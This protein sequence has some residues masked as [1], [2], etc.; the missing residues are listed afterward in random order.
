MYKELPLFVRP[1]TS[2]LNM[3]TGTLSGLSAAGVKGGRVAVIGGGVSGVG[4]ADTLRRLGYVPVVFEKSGR[5]GG[6]WC[7]AYAGSRLQNTCEGYEFIGFSWDDAGIVPDRHPTR[8]QVLD[9]IDA[10]VRIFGLDLRLSTEVTRMDES[11]EAARPGWLVTT[12]RVRH[13]AGSGICDDAD[14]VGA[15]HDIVSL[16]IHESSSFFDY[17]IVATGHFSEKLRPTYPGEE[18]FRG[19]V[20][21]SLS[22]NPSSVFADAKKRGVV[23]VGMGKT[24]LDLA[25]FA[26]RVGAPCTH[27]FRTPRWLLPDYLLQMVCYSRVLFSRLGGSLMVPCWDQPDAAQRFLH[28]S[29]ALLVAGFWAM[30]ERIITFSHFL[31]PRDGMPPKEKPAAFAAAHARLQLLQPEHTL[32]H[33]LRSALALAPSTLHAEVARGAIVPHRGEIVSFSENGVIL[34]NGTEVPC[35]VVALGTGSPVTTL[36][37]LP[38]KYA[39][40]IEEGQNG[41]YRHVIH[42]DIPRVAWA[43]MNHCFAHFTAVELGTLWTS[44]FWRDEIA[45]PTPEAMHESMARVLA[46]KAKHTAA[47]TCMPYNVNVRFQAYADT[48]SRELGISAYRKLPNMAAE[49]LLRY[50]P[51]DYDSALSEYHVSRKA[52]AG[53]RLTSLHVDM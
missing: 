33:D 2:C 24:A 29:L 23:V 36:L 44:A 14:N 22:L 45:L 15:A 20:V 27:I 30:I 25:A 48:L 31:A 43:G 39:R 18:H 19:Q 9:Y 42:P 10:A 35:D 52:R 12:S 17:V 41:L 47:E 34:N 40:L 32:R 28:T 49:F 16:S 13:E 50:V 4:A 53:K 51:A 21:T 6:Q 7:G 37:F 11:T 8:E 1:L 26:A 3:P 5:A 46:W 38:R